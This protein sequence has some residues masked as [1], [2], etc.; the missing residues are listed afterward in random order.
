LAVLL[1]VVA[2]RSVAL[3]LVP[4]NL[5]RHR[6]F[7]A[8]NGVSICIY[9]SL[10]GSVYLM[11]QFFQ[12]AQ[13]TS[14]IVAALRF[15]PWPA[16]ALIVAPLVGSW[17]ARFGN[18]VFLILGMTLHAS[19]LTWFALVVHASAPYAALCA[20]LVL[21]GVGIACVFPTVSSEVVSSVP[22]DRM[23][24]A[25]GVNGSIRELGGVFGVALAATVF[26]HRGAYATTHTF[27]AGFVDAMWA[28]VVLSVVGV[29][30]ALV[31]A[32]RR[33]ADAAPP[34]EPA[35]AR[36]AMSGIGR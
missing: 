18:R 7:S 3:P 27:T 2:E 32:P 33:V 16:P 22:P 8:A 34:A 23:G 9:A 29:V 10:S 6:G 12:I 14:P 21:S 35:S 4:M 11:S 28:C 15:A 20:P 36:Q 13:H 19:G 24:T 25:S 1:F 26:A 5:F 17:A 31:A 30:A